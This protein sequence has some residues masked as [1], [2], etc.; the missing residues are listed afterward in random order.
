MEKYL[1]VFFWTSTGCW[2]F[3]QFIDSIRGLFHKAPNLRFY[4]FLSI[5]MQTT[6]NFKHLAGTYVACLFPTAFN[7]VGD[8][9]TTVFVGWNHC[10]LLELWNGVRVWWLFVQTTRIFVFGFMITWPRILHNTRPVHRA[11]NVR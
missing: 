11:I 1:Y 3:D 2:Y 10:S 5:F 6:H 9:R 8:K 7:I 4:K